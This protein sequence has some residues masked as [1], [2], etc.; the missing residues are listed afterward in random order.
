MPTKKRSPRRVRRPAGVL[1]AVGG[2]SSLRAALKRQIGVCERCVL[3]DA[4]REAGASFLRGSLDEGRLSPGEE[5][6]RQ[7]LEAHAEAGFGD[8]RIEALEWA[9]PWIEVHCAAQE[10][11]A[12]DYTAG[13]MEGFLAALLQAEGR[14]DEHVVCREILCAGNGAQECRF[15]AGSWSAMLDRAAVTGEHRHVKDGHSNTSSPLGTPV[16]CDVLTRNDDLELQVAGLNDQV[17]DYERLLTNILMNSAD[18]IISIDRSRRILTW[19]RGAEL[20]YGYHP[21]EI[22]GQ[23]FE[24]LVPEDLLRDGELERIDKAMIEQGLL[25][26]YQT[27]RLTKDGRRVTV[28]VSCTSLHDSRGRHIGRSVI[29][30]DITERKRLQQELIRSEKLSA[31]GK[32]SAHVAHEVRN[33]LSSIRLNLELLREE[34][35]GG[36]KADLNEA[37]VL[38]QAIHTEVDVLTRFTDEYLQFARLPQLHL[39]ELDLGELAEELAAF[40]EEEAARRGIT[41]RARAESEVPPIQADASKLRQ[42]L[43]NLVRNAIEAMPGGGSIELVLRRREEAAELTVVDNGPGIASELLPR[44]FEPFFTTKEGGTGLGLALSLQILHEHGG[45]LECSSAPGQGAAFTLTLPL[46]R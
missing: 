8:F 3:H 46:E 25:R 7:A 23:P 44:I 15:E 34:F 24:R 32:L 29:H 21:E 1:L 4:G 28:E 6:F 36:E 39:E 30:R 5:G 26:N 11:W 33:P 9:G 19:N 12:C 10:L 43:L 16:L 31:I 37:K 14:S 27:D 45:H 40:L 38:L 20:M 42:V 18:A 17:L 35:D 2:F 13:V 22:V 41:I